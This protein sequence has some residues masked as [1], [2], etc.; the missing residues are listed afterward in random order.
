MYNQY[1]N[2]F[3]NDW[4]LNQQFEQ[5]VYILHNTF[6][7]DALLRNNLEK[8]Q[9]LSNKPWITKDILKASKIK[10]KL[11]K[12][13]LN[14]T[15]EDHYRYKSFRNKLAHDKEQAKQKFYTKTVNETK[16]NINAYGQ[17]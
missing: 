4:N 11:Y 16:H 17:Q 10:C 7:K 8:E 14:G 1:S 2:F 9:K 3:S 13:S 12:A 6:N 5:F 15:T